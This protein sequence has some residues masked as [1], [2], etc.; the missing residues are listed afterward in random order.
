MI[1]LSGYKSPSGYMD[2]SWAVIGVTAVSAVAK[3]IGGVAKKRAA[4]KPNRYV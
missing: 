1:N 4:K 2:R 3:G